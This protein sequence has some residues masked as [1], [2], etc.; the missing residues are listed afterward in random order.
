M[1]VLGIHLG[2]DSSAA[3]IRNGEV[4]GAIQ[5]ERFTR[6]KN[7]SGYPRFSQKY[8]LNEAG[9]DTKDIDALVVAGKMLGK[10][11]PIDILL[12]RLG[13]NI[14]RH[15]LRLK[16][17]NAGIRRSDRLRRLLYDENKA[18]KLIN[19]E[20]DRQGF[21]N[22][23]IEFFDHHTCH[24]ASAFFSSPFEEAL[25][26]TQDGKGDGSSGTVFKGD[27][28][29]LTELARQSH[30][31][32]IGQI[33]AEVTRYLGFRPNRHEGKVT[34]LAALGE[35]S[36]SQMVF[37]DLIDHINEVVHQSNVLESVR[38]PFFGEKLS[39][40]LA[41]LANHPDILPYELKAAK[42]GIW[43]KENF[44]GIPRED[45]AAGLQQSVEE[46]VVRWCNHNVE[47]LVGNGST[48]ICVA[49]GLFANVK[50]NQM[51][52]EKVPKLKNLY[53]QPAMGD[54][55]LA[56]GAAQLY[57]N[58]NCSNIT[59]NKPLK[60]AYLGSSHTDEQLKI[61]LSDF[62]KFIIWEVS[63][64][65]EKKIGK[66]LHE[67]SVIG[68]F[69]GKTEWGPRALGNRSILIRPTEKN[70]NDTVNKRL[71]RSDFMPFAPSVLDYRAK[72]YFVDYDKSQIASEFMTVTYDVFPEKA[73]Q[74]GA[75]VHVDN[76]A[77]PQI[78]R[79]NLNSSF[80][81]ILQAYEYFSGIGCV[82]NTSFNLHEEP[83]V[84]SPVD[85]LRALLQGAVDILA[86]EN[87]LVKIK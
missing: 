58:N 87:Y 36:S 4:V 53:V 32:S 54:S 22:S 35:P 15:W 49:G 61:A 43:L 64:N 68:R 52:K 26:L 42:I 20:L 2:H 60:H 57:W 59:K 8:L 37:D 69:R 47:K 74:I 5:E 81:K 40:K 11:M 25:V 66:L 75:V 77:R 84:E 79:K 51:V 48:D 50:V 31:N 34:G 17:L 73:L 67:G 30:E 86:I 23:I 24:A 63:E 71:R 38:I 18:K 16:T 83:I 41:R 12:E 46:W 9:I 27:N 21:S 28:N 44:S 6:V 10:E 14:G 65:I 82:V 39:T 76:T 45:V 62:E 72:D 55:G 19:E 33:Y 78:V 13:V 70:I 56:L 85:A 80:Y 7:Y 29:G 1:F 3:L